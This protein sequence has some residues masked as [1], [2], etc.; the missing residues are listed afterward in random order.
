MSL[1]IT[2]VKIIRSRH[3][4][5]EKELASVEIVM[6]ETVKITGIRI[7]KGKFGPFVGWPMAWSWEDKRP[8]RIVIPL[9]KITELE[10]DRIIME[11][12]TQ[13]ILP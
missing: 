12:F 3:G 2:S 10:Y 11:H 5:T 6:G 7:I 13:N 9:S 4:K 1:L 8:F